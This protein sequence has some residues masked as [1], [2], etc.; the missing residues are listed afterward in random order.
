[1]ATTQ[2]GQQPAPRE[3]RVHIG[4]NAQGKITV[5]PNPFWIYRCE[6]EQVRWVCVQ[7]HTHGD[8]KNDPCFI[9][10]FE[11]ETGSPF[12]RSQFQGHGDVSDL[13]RADA[14]DNQEY[15]YTVRIGNKIWDPGGGVRP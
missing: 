15:K 9:V 14:T 5:E 2:T 10:D 1:M 11:K 4:L 7:R 8:P 3:V 6:Q 13:P 12:V